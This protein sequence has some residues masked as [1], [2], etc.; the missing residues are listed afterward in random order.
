MER[1]VDGKKYGLESRRYIFISNGV[2]ERVVEEKA[3][4][5][6]QQVAF[7]SDERAQV[8]TWWAGH[9]CLGQIQSSKSPKQSARHSA[10]T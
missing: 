5:A 7:S 1:C 3:W 6:K 2:V 10:H 4:T 8:V 9:S